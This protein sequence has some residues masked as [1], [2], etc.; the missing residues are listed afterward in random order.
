MREN[1]RKH[2]STH[3]N[4]STENL[5]PYPSRSLVF[6]FQCPISR[7]TGQVPV[8]ELTFPIKPLPDLTP[9]VPSS[10]QSGSDLVRQIRWSEALAC[11]GGGLG[12]DYRPLLG[13]RNRKR[14]ARIHHKQPAFYEDRRRPTPPVPTGTPPKFA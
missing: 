10:R 6:N 5:V 12:V 9:L 14:S 13:P 2:N 4:G 11:R 7:E 8:P 3:W 1:R